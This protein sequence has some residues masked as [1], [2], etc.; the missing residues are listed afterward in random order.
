MLTLL[1][2]Q[3]CIELFHMWVLIF[4]PYAPTGFKMLMWIFLYMLPLK[5]KF[6]EITITR[7]VENM[8]RF[9]NINET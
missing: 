4:N 8:L 6:V 3:W 7:Q 9:D 2:T 5:Y 1:K